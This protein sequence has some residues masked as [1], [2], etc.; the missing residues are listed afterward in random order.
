MLRD[1]NLPIA[2][3]GDAGGLSPG[4]AVSPGPLE[5]IFTSRFHARPTLCVLDL[6]GAVG[7]EL[8]PPRSVFAGRARMVRPDR[9]AQIARPQHPAPRC[10]I[11]AGPMQGAAVAR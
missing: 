10:P 11:T 1:D 9:H 8:S 2:T 7:L 3:E 5:Q 4:P 6:Q